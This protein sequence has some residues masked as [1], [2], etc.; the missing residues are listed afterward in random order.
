MNSKSGRTLKTDEMEIKYKKLGAENFS[1]TSLDGFERRQ[2]V[3]RCWRK[4]NGEYA[5]LPVKYIEDWTVE[6]KRALAR[7]ML[8]GVLQGGVLFGAEA[9]GR[10]IGFAYVDRALFGSGKQYCDLAEFYVS[11]PF[12]NM[13]IG[14]RL[15]M[16]ACGAAAEFG[17]QKLYISA[18]S[19]EDSIAA[20]KKLGCV[21]ATEIN[22]RFAEKEPCDLQ[23]EYVL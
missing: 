21:F 7:R 3:E 23:L 8:D 11:A 4:V 5:L 10:I 1:V 19:A 18:H 20:Y 9:D 16:L 14:K 17:A 13:G 6:E 12:R 2:S 22:V 15:F